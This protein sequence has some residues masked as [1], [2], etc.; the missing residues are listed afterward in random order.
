MKQRTKRER[1]ATCRQLY[2]RSY[3]CNRIRYVYSEGQVESIAKCNSIVSSRLNFVNVKRQENEHETRR[4]AWS[5]DWTTRTRVHLWTCSLFSLE[6]MKTNAHD[7][8]IKTR[9]L[10]NEMKIKSIN[11]QHRSFIE[12]SMYNY[13]IRLVRTRDYVG[14]CR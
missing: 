1:S 4:V 12:Q 7:R 10:S 11:E 9:S 8:L 14:Q 3:E 13:R 2:S 5:D 6:T